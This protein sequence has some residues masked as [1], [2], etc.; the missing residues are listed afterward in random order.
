MVANMK[1]LGQEEYD[2]IY[3]M[4]CSKNKNKYIT[5]SVAMKI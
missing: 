5:K 4:K 2:K 1:K 3:Y